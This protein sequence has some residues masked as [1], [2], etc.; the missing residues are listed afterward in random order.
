MIIGND[1]TGDLSAL[2]EV[3]VFSGRDNSNW[4]RGH[5]LG[6]DIGFQMKVFADTSIFGINDGR[7]SKLFVFKG[8]EWTYDNTTIIINYD[9][10]WDIEPAEPLGLSVLYLLLKAI[11][12]GDHEES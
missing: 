4:I 9:R 11:D 1:C 12:G 7:V 6:Q 2:L 8:K 5:L 10:G 3:A